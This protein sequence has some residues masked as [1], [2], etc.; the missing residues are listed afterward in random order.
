MKIVLLTAYLSREAGGLEQ[1]VPGLANAIAINKLDVSIVGL[2]S[3]EDVISP[4]YD[5]TDTHACDVK[6]F[7]RFGYS[8]VLENTILQLEPDL[9]HLQ[10]IWLYSSIVN[11]RVCAKLHI[12]YIISPR[13][14]LDS[15][16]L[17]RSKYKKGL[18]LKLFENKHIHNSA[19]IHALNCQEADSV[20][21]FGYNGKIA[22]I[23]NGINVPDTKPQ[24]I[25][26]QNKYVLFLGRLDEKKSVIELVQGWKQVSQSADIAGWELR[27]VGYGLQSYI[28]KIKISIEKLGMDRSIKFLGPLYGDDKRKI[29]SEASAF[30]LPSKSEGLP[31]AVLEAWSYAVPVLMTKECNLVDSFSKNAALQIY[32]SVNGIASGLKQLFSMPMTELDRYSNNGL[33]YVN[34]KYSLPVVGGSMAALYKSLAQ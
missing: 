11:M 20:R 31:M 1:S 32:S 28:D 33:E 26:N 23:P 18:I 12:P 14:M 21:Q 22:V 9:V 19:C 17:S 6:Y 3:R 4:S 30:I 10:H 16:A 7:R 25:S 27:I 15:W 29:L 5:F 2:S 8:K 13:G 34:T 24:L